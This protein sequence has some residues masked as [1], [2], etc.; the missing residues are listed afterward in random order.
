MTE[1]I[2]H[3][4]AIDQNGNIA[5]ETANIHIKIPDIEIIDLKKNGEETTDIIAKISNDIDE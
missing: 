1:D 5:Q 3:F 4:T 2:F